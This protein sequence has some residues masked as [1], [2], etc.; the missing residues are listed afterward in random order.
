MEKYFRTEERELINV[1]DHT[2][3][4]LK[5]WPNLKIHIGTDSQDRGD[6]T[7]YATCIVYRYGNRGAHYV[8]FKEEVPR[9][10]DM[11]TRLYGEA[12]RTLEAAQLLDGEIPVSFEALE[13]DYNNIPHW[14]SNKLVSSIRGWVRGMNYKGVFKNHEGM[15]IASKAADRVCRR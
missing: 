4:Q 11:F 6:K 14:A 12:T 9:I 13:F 3:E 5:K 2:L 15:M 8:Y 10:R 1:V 7:V